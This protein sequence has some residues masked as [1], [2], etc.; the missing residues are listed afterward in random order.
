M[1]HDAPSYVER[2]ADIVLYEG[3]KRG[4]FCYVLT[5]RQMGKSS[6]MVRTAARLRAEGTAVVMLDL[7]AVGQ[8][9]TVE[10]WYDGLLRLLG[11]QLGLEV[12]LEGFWQ[13]ECRLNPL[14]RFTTAIRQVVLRKSSQPLVIFVDEIDI[15]RSLPFS[16][17]EF[18]AAIRECYNR[19]PKDSE[20]E[21]LTFCLLGVATPSDL[22][23]DARL[24]PF[25]IGQ[26]IELS[27]FTDRE[28]APLEQ[29]L[30]ADGR[31]GH[32]L[33]RRV[34]HWT[35][36]HPYLTQRLCRSIA[37][38]LTATS[39]RSVDR[40]C[41]ELFLSSRARE[42]DDNLLFVRERL[43]KSDA[44]PAA[45]LT[46]YLQ[47]LGRRQPV[48]DSERDPAVNGLRLSGV[49]RNAE[50]RL[51][52][53]NRIYKR[54]FDHEWV[55]S[56]LPDQEA[57]LQ[58]LSFRRGSAAA[59]RATAGLVVA[60][61]GI[62]LSFSRL[63]D[64]FTHWSYDLLFFSRRATPPNEVVI[65]YLDERS[66]KELNVDNNSLRGLHARLLERLKADQAR[67]VVLDILFVDAKDSVTDNKLAQ[68][69]KAHGNVVLAAGLSPLSHPEYVGES[70]FLPKKE[71]VEAAK[72]CGIADQVV[73]SDG[74]IRTHYPGIDQFPSL[75][76][77]TAEVIG[78]PVTR[79]PDNRLQE[80]WLNY[81][82]PPDTFAH[83][84]F[85]EALEPEGV[86]AGFFR[87]KVVYVGGRRLTEPLDP[88]KQVDEFRTP[89]TWLAKT[90]IPGV[91]VQA[92]EFLNLVRQDWLTRPAPA[93]QMG[94]LLLAGL[95]LG[96]CLP[97]FRPAR[98][99]LLAVAAAL[100]VAGL[101]F[102][103]FWLLRI[104]FPWLLIVAIEIPVALLSSVIIATI[105]LHIE[106]ES[107]FSPA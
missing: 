2:R 37:E 53:R 94:V 24:T 25:N 1:R 20:F 77:R 45:L 83:V 41:Q 80:R 23:R 59:L 44:T 67:A 47:I 39:V 29:G 75:A 10:Q 43:V 72:A 62:S 49:V 58:R 13:A 34:F 46:L 7:T 5:P 35:S 15:V 32:K 96:Y 93:V 42:R 31:R 16:T 71:F 85:Y 19:R 81:Y 66:R 12:A 95:T 14:L 9:L 18:F 50:G 28:V 17:D 54:V 99:T 73:E 101:S 64:G 65:V 82:G 56:N 3:L 60:M 74:V 86:L 27:D 91:E 68:A 57:R 26:R 92:T 51:Q 105:K 61:L 8:H 89:F 55:L 30:N 40:H 11:S 78:A 97:L 52:I 107:G 6:L 48:G 70:I 63:G 104:W 4:E 36:G 22:I 103:C 69:I 84:S 98:A 100:L 33:L 38:D 79:E 88:K 102:L 87:D 21:R 106:Q 76:W 90:I